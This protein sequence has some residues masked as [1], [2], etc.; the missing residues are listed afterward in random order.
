MVEQDVKYNVKIDEEDISQQLERI[1]EKI[2]LTMGSLSFG[3]NSIPQAS[4]VITGDFTGFGGGG[5]MM[6]AFSGGSPASFLDDSADYLRLGYSKFNEDARRLGLLSSPSY[7][8]I[9][10]TPVNSVGPDSVFGSLNALYNPF[11]GGYDPNTAGGFLSDYQQTASN[12]LGEKTSGFLTNSGFTTLGTTAGFAVG[13]VGGAFTGGTLGAIADLSFGVT[14]RRAIERDSLASGFKTIAEESFGSIG[15]SDARALAGILQDKAYSVEGISQNYKMDFLEQNVLDFSQA[16]GFSNVGSVEEMEDVLRGVVEN[17]RDFANKI[18][19]SQK[20]AA[21]IM[22][23]LQRDMLATT[24]E[25]GSLGTQLGYEGDVTGLGASGV[26]SFGL[27]GVEMLKG[28]GVGAQASFAMARESLLQAQR[29][30][31]TDPSSRKLIA[32]MGGV[33]AFAL[34]NMESN[35]NYMMSGQGMMTTA[36]LLGGYNPGDGT[37]GLLSSAANYFSGDPRKLLG[38]PAQQGDILA[39]LPAEIIQTMGVTN[40][41]EVIDNLPGLKNSDGTINRELLVSGLMGRDGIS[42][43]QAKALLRQYED[44]GTS[45]PVGDEVSSI[46]REISDITASSNYS[47]FMPEVK[48]F[49][50]NMGVSRSAENLYNSITDSVED[51]FQGVGDRRT[52]TYRADVSR[53]PETVRNALESIR[54]NEAYNALGEGINLGLSKKETAKTVFDSLRDEGLYAEGDFTTF[55]NRF[56]FSQEYDATNIKEADAKLAQRLGT[57]SFIKNEFGVANTV[58]DIKNEFALTLY[59]NKL[60]NANIPEE[61]IKSLM[62]NM[63]GG[64]FDMVDDSIRSSVQAQMATD[65]YGVTSLEELNNLSKG[66]STAIDILRGGKLEKHGLS[67]QEA[68]ESE[69]EQLI[70]MASA[71]AGKGFMSKTGISEVISQITE[72]GEVDPRLL[73]NKTDRDIARYINSQYEDKITALGSMFGQGGAYVLEANISEQA[74]EVASLLGFAVPETMSLESAAYEKLKTLNKLGDATD[75]T[76]EGVFSGSKED[77]LDSLESAGLDRESISGRVSKAKTLM[78]I[79]KV[80]KENAGNVRG[81]EIL[82]NLDYNEASGAIGEFYKNSTEKTMDRVIEKLDG[83]FTSVVGGGSALRVISHSTQSEGR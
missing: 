57:K 52:G 34:G 69:A 50:K 43:N 67:L 65:G 74:R 5:G 82:S 51:F 63:V 76:I 42:A 36:A 12:V 58:D 68:A 79:V 71:Q 55:Q 47:T 53:A 21:Q 38:L 17:T 14:A 24:S 78:D 48:A 35:Y 44:F 30:G 80:V 70:M 16:G 26:V 20:E 25:M 33:E 75:F 54:G 46:M 1:R 49:F 81:E 72:R 9:A 64:A 32:D 66:S 15:S 31:L 2:D 23:Q 77:I 28:T 13:G 29:V 6:G 22:A 41:F 11:Y 8:S 73:N 59:Y 39:G 62:S 19:S 61:E 18:G 4:D 45:N 27:Q 83:V 10:P 37:Q 60:K 40:M 56:E 3:S 7:P